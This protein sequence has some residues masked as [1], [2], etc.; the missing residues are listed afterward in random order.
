MKEARG[1]ADKDRGPEEKFVVVVVDD[2]DGGG[3]GDGG[4][5][6]VFTHTKGNWKRSSMRS[7][8]C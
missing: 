3:D 6:M 1:L 8:C 2:G 4:Q 7:W 5:L